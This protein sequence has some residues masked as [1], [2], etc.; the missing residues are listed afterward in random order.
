MGE[1][2]GNEMMLVK[3]IQNFPVNSDDLTDKSDVRT[4]SAP[5]AGSYFSAP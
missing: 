2:D 4:R 3:H 5:G 1:D